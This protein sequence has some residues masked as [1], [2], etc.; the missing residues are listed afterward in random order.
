MHKHLGLFFFALCFLTGCRPVDDPRAMAANAIQIEITADGCQ[1][2]ELIVPAGERIDLQIDNQTPYD[3]NWSVLLFD[4][5]GEFDR[6]D[7]ENQLVNK[8]ALAQTQTT[9]QF[10]AP[11]LTA[12]YMTV[13]YP[14]FDP[15]QFDLINLLVVQPYEK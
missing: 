14:D 10:F 9:A 7:T 8:A 5:Q 11:R 3:Y 4:M 6:A 1:P 12:T 15:Q 2:Y 13:C